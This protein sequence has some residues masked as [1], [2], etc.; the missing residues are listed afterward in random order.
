L[1]QGLAYG[2]ENAQ[3]GDSELIVSGD[4]G[5]PKAEFPTRQNGPVRQ[6]FFDETPNTNYIK[7]E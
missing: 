3:Y 6:L 1:Q 7:P 4:G 2:I 5:S